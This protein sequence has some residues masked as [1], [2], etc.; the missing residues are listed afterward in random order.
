MRI[1]QRRCRRRRRR[2]RCCLR[3]PCTFVVRVSL[4]F[5]IAEYLILI[6]IS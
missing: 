6:I 4:L 3:I 2:R 5:T 1:K